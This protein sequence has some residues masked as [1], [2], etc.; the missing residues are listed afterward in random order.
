MYLTR[1]GPPIVLHLA[2][3][4]GVK[5]DLLKHRIRITLDLPLDDDSLALRGQLTAL[6]ANPDVFKPIEVTLQAM[7]VK[8]QDFQLGMRGLE[9]ALD[10]TLAHQADPLT[11]ELPD[12]TTASWPN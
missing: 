4:A 7:K 1:Q 11:G 8:V 5:A 6:A 2:E 3:L 10:Q 9:D 12:E